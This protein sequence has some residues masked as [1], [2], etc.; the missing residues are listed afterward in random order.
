M[1]VVLS[2]LQMFKDEKKNFKKNINK[3]DYLDY[4]K[5][6]NEK[7]FGVKEFTKQDM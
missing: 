7:F 5:K 3:S 2:C 1:V 4:N 6:R